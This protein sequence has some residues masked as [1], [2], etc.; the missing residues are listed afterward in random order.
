VEW[1]SVGDALVGSVLVVEP[2]VLA[3]GVE[4]VVLVPDQGPVQQLV[5]AGLH[6]VPLEN[7][8]GLLTWGFAG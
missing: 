5:T 6:P 8:I 3:E 1:S 7:R 4:Q 2:F